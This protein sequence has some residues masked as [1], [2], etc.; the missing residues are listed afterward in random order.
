MTAPAQASGARPVHDDASPARGSRAARAAPPGRV[1]PARVAGTVAGALTIVGALVWTALPLARAGALRP[2]AVAVLVA[3]AA[4]LLASQAATPHDGPPLGLVLAVPAVGAALLVVVPTSGALRVAGQAAAGLAAAALVAQGARTHGGRP[5]VPDTVVAATL[6]AAVGTTVLLVDPFVVV[7]CDLTCAPN[8]LALA[9]RP[10]IV[11]LV[12]ALAGCGA[13]LWCAVR[14]AR[15]RGAA[16][17]A[18]V[19]AVGVTWLV[20]ALRAGPPTEDAQALR[21]GATAQLAV[22]VALLGPGVVRW[23]RLVGQRTRTARLAA[24]LEG[25]AAVDV[26]AWLAVLTRDPHL[27]VLPIGRDV[28]GG[29]V[30][31]TVTRAGEPVAVVAHSRAATARVLRALT[32]LVA[33]LTANA[34]RRE[35]ETEHLEHLVAARQEVVRRVDAARSGLERDLHDGAQQRLLLLGM[36]LAAARDQDRA[37][38]SQYEAAVRAATSALQEVRR[39]SHGAVPPALARLGLTEALRAYAED[40]AVPCR[41]EVDGGRPDGLAPLAADVEQAVYRVVVAQVDDAVRGDARRVDVTL[42]PDAP[43]GR[44]R[45]QVEHDGRSTIAEDDVT[46]RVGAVRGTWSRTVEPGRTCGTVVVPCG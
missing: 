1:P 43:H 18:L 14:T 6:V 23:W 34:V 37:H 3:G 4:L 5:R 31:T 36:V 8:P 16:T 44:L 9:H 42:H 35:E 24:D 45:V 21:V 13:V 32:P 33:A 25:S 17:D 2:V 27:R 40:C 7:S 38:A 11:R 12:A 26:A 30:S 41:V 10:E 39:L 22:V 19:A 29:L 28:P 15:R 46:D 20:A